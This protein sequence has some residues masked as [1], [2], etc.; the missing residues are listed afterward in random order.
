MILSPPRRLTAALLAAL[1]WAG[2][3]GCGREA[4]E[5]P[6][7]GTEGPRRGGQVVV[8]LTSDMT[9]VNTLVVSSSVTTAE[10]ERQ[11]FLPLVS[12]QP[13]YK[14]VEPELAESWEFSDDHR[15]LTF[16]LRRD[17]LW[18]D[19]T[20]VTADDVAFSFAA[21]TDESIA[22]ENASAFEK[23][24][25]VEVVDAH[26]VRFHFDQVYATQLLDAGTF[27]VILPKHAWGAL[28]F[29]EWRDSG[30]WFR[31]HLVVDGPFDLASWTPQQEIVL[32]RNPLY[33]RD[34]LPYLDRVVFRVVPDQTSQLTQLLNGQV[35]YLF[36]LAPDSVGQVESSPDARVIPY[37]TR[38]FIAVAWNTRRGEIADPRVRRALAHGIDRQALVESIWGSY[39]RPL[40]GPIPPDVWLYDETLEA[41]AYDPDEARRL[42]AEAGWTDGDGDGVVDRQGRPLRLRLMT[43]AGNRQRE[44]AAVLIQDQLGRVGV[45][46]VADVL[47]FNTMVQQAFAGDFDGLIFGMVLPTTMDLRFAFH[48]DQIEQGSNIV[49]YS[50]PEADRLL[51]EIREQ[52]T[53]EAAQPLF[54]RL[55]RI[56]QED[57]PYTF[58]WQSQR[59]VGV[60]KRVHGPAPNHLFSLWDLEEWWVDEGR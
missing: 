51:E 2:C 31:E 3:A 10:I 9:G 42:L 41:L 60:H 45:A 27:G 23:I 29:S 37:W 8:A 52:P 13:D 21:W 24:D 4:S 35:D 39:A 49:A 19:G 5:D 40:A 14:T 56:V 36:Q 33:Y 11:L 1:L 58:L 25:R 50:N 53:L 12:E 16:H 22:W 47:E 44:D 38:G 20:P 57:Q 7:A 32:Q 15:V 26:T 43:N 34:D 17:V 6:A 18:S 28:P 59:L 30:D 54:D 55:Q 46:V 48:S